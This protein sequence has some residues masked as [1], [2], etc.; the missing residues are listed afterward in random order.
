VRKLRTLRRDKDGSGE[1]GVGNRLR[2]LIIVSATKQKNAG[3]KKRRL[4]FS[5][6]HFSV[7]WFLVAEIAIKA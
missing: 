5:V 3:Q 6:Q 4:H 7:W 2:A 1:W